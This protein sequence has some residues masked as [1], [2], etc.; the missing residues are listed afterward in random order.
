MFCHRVAVLS[1]AQDKTRKKHKPIAQWDVMHFERSNKHTC[2]NSFRSNFSTKFIC[3]RHATVL[4]ITDFSLSHSFR[5]VTFFFVLLKRMTCSDY[6][7]KKWYDETEW[8]KE[9]DMER[10]WEGIT[11][12]ECL[13]Y[14]CH[15]FILFFSH[16]NSGSSI[17]FLFSIV[18]LIIAFDFVFRCVR[19]LVRDFCVC[20]AVRKYLHIYFICWF[21]TVLTNRF[22]YT[23]HMCASGAL[24]LC[25][26][27]HAPYNEKGIYSERQ[28]DEHMWAFKIQ[29]R[30]HCRIYT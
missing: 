1:L 28:T 18:F 11:S 27:I 14:P 3:H 5:F 10:E 30:L 7:G 4:K 24:R 29:T 19:L 25:L 16:M 9:R 21:V 20:C 26:P 8:E 22:R 23:I 6:R 13:V 15:K 2:R 12:F 17:S